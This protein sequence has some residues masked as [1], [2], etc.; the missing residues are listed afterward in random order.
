MSQRVMNEIETRYS[1]PMDQLRTK[2]AVASSA[3]FMV[4]LVSPDDA[5]DPTKIEGLRRAARETGIDL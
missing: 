3:G 4:S 1:N 5:D 2:G